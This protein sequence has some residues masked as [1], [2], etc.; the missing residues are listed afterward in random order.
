VSIRTNC[1][2]REMMAQ[3]LRLYSVSSTYP[4]PIISDIGGSDSPGPCRHLHI[5]TDTL[6]K[7]IKIKMHPL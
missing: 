7:I 3:W 2:P 5:F 6:L 4:E 1:K